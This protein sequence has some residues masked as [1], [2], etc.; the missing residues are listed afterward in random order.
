MRCC[1][2]SRGGDTT[3][4]LSEVGKELNGGLRGQVQTWEGD[5]RGQDTP[6]KI[7][8][9]DYNQNKEKCEKYW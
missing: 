4:G 2:T 9:Y 6:E 1:G 8:G 5:E 7:T 3:D